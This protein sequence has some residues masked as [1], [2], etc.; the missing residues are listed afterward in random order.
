LKILNFATGS[1]TNPNWTKTPEGFLRCRARVLS[2]RI[3]SYDKSEIQG[4]PYFITENPVNMFVPESSLSEPDSLRS[5]EGVPVVAGDH[6]WQELE[7]AGTNVCGA[8]AGTPSIEGP[9]LLIDL[10]VTNPE[11]ISSIESGLLPEVSAAY[12]SQV[13]FKPGIWQGEKY[14]ALQKEIRFNHIAIIPAGYGRAGSDVRI[15]N[16]KGE[17]KMSVHFENGR[18]KAE[19]EIMEKLNRSRNLEMGNQTRTNEEKL[20]IQI[21]NVDQGIALERKAQTEA[22]KASRIVSKNLILS[23]MDYNRAF[24]NSRQQRRLALETVKARRAD[25]ERRLGLLKG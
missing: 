8:T 2:E 4:V 17:T 11:A 13:E 24:N 9:Y 1:Q 15:L 25:C 19:R 22:L 5:L 18:M 21:E 16:K 14:Q 10:L 12:S 23:P 20:G 3:L 6:T 7:N